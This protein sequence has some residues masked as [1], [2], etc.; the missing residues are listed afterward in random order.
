MPESFGFDH[1][2]V[3]EVERALFKMQPPPEET[4]MPVPSGLG[5]LVCST[6]GA[7]FVDDPR[8]DTEIQAAITLTIR[9]TLRG[10]TWHFRD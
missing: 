5:D 3:D 4:Q 7:C 1:E 10:R 9:S 6:W 2:D 8:S